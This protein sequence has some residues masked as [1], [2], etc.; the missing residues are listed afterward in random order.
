MTT[1]P[2]SMNPM[3][4]GWV[5]T[6]ALLV[7]VLLVAAVAA[8]AVWRASTFKTELGPQPICRL[9][10]A[11][12][13]LRDA[14]YQLN[15]QLDDD[16]T[17]GTIVQVEEAMGAGATASRPLPSPVVLNWGDE[18]FATHPRSRR[19]ALSG[20][21][22]S[23]EVI[24]GVGADL[25]TAW[26]PRLSL[27]LR[28]GASY[29]LGFGDV[30]KLTRA[31]GNMSNKFSDECVESYRVAVTRD[32]PEWFKVVQETVVATGLKYEFR[33]QDQ[34]GLE[35]RVAVAKDAKEQLSKK[36]PGELFNIHFAEGS[37]GSH[38]LVVDG[39]VVLAYRLRPIEPIY[40]P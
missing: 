6:T 19:F 15:S 24:F 31:K 13:R 37:R 40:A 21:D 1:K 38:T 7:A 26:A 17:P 14:G 32:R 28:E 20:C 27:Q 11:L 4:N 3:R 30:F 36:F 22:Q 29:Q 18:C 35:A 25:G 8:Y 12:S 34:L 23:S 2:P 16:Y 33:F 39:V 10:E 9:N 5:R